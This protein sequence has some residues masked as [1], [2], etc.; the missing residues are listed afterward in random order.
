MY[1]L[2]QITVTK[3]YKLQKYIQKLLIMVT[4]NSFKKGFTIMV[5]K[6]FKKVPMMVLKV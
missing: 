6:K 1:L 3:S 2:L 4:S 5:P